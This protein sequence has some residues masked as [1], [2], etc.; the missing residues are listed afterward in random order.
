MRKPIDYVGARAGAPIDSR[1]LDPEPDKPVAIVV[2]R[3]NLIDTKRLT[4]TEAV[5]LAADLI[6][7]IARVMEQNQRAAREEAQQ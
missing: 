1:E 6:G 2:T 4:L 3:G 7:I 5:R